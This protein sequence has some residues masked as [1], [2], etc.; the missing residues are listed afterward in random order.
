MLMVVAMSIVYCDV[1]Y[2]IRSRR[3]TDFV[4]RALWV[5][6]ETVFPEYG[7]L[8]SIILIAFIAFGGLALTY[9]FAE[10]EPFLW[11]ISAGTVIGFAIFG[12]AGFV[13]ASFLGLNT[14]TVLISL[15]VSFSPVFLLRTG[16]LRARFRKEWQ[17]AK[18]KLLRVNRRQSFSQSGT[19]D[20]A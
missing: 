10:D 13:I 19:A 12:T 8:L 14:T 2:Q 4:L 5:N 17:R 11:R 1:Y 6:L 9:L 15:A 3:I 16:N 18:G 20:C 7:M